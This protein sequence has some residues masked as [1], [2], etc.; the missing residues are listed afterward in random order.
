MLA[1]CKVEIEAGRARGRGEDVTVD[2]CMCMYHSTEMCGRVAYKVVQI[3]DD[4]VTLR[5]A[6]LNVSTVMCGRSEFTK[7]E[8]RSTC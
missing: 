7:V 6:A 8:A 4:S 2:V 5:D 1:R 3:F